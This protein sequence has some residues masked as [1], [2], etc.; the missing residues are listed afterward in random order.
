VYTFHSTVGKRIFYACTPIEPVF[1]YKSFKISTG[2]TQYYT[3]L[4]ASQVRSLSPV[5]DED[6]EVDLPFE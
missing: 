4:L 5:V 1:H 3:K 6:L 2:Y